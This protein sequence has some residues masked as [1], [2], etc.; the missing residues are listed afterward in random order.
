MDNN[1]E[2]TQLTLAFVDR[3]VDN[4]HIEQRLLDGYI[5][6]TALCK[7]CG[8]EMKHYLS[9]S[10]TRDFV[11]EL[12]SEVGI[13]TSALI[14]IVRG[15]DP[16]FQGTWV[17]PQ[18]AI[19]LAQWASPKFAVAV[20][21]WVFE[22]MQGNIKTQG[23][24]PYHLRRY[25]LNRKKIPQGYFSMFNEIVTALIAP[26]EEQG[27][28]LPDKLV[29]DIS[30]GKIFCNWL[31]DVKNIDPSQFPTYEHEYGDGRKIPG[32]RLYPDTLL[33]EFRAHF[34][35]VWLLERATE[36]FK[37]KDT[38]ALP[39]LAK[40]MDELPPVENP[41]RLSFPLDDKLNQAL[42]YDPKKDKRND[43]ESEEL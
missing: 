2:T 37:K 4:N 8:K 25:M 31:R 24:L 14:Q 16:R 6:A 28:T 40:M 3:Q 32:V 41:K 1:A 43:N 34:N 9:N 11:N 42:N 12:S 18:V 27:Y 30:E 10:S 13:P 5:N 35:N 29:P 23:N 39:F 33:P 19:H 7:A 15:G 38:K 21:K 22:W 36:Y 20:S 26:L 17:H